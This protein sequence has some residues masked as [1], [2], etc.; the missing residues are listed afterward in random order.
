[1]EQVGTNP[2]IVGWLQGVVNL[3]PTAKSDLNPDTCTEEV[4]SLQLPVPNVQ[5]MKVH[6]KYIA[7]YCNLN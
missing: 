1:M 7:V 3:I 2:H 6:I 5:K 4:F